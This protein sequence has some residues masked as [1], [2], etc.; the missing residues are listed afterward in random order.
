MKIVGI[1]GLPRSGKDSL[2][3]Q[4]MNGGYFGVSLGDIVRDESRKR[5]SAAKDPISVAN[6]TETANWLRQNQGPDFALKEALNRYER[7]QAAAE[8]I[9]MVVFSVR[10]PVEVD[11]IL[12]HHGELIWVE[13]DDNVRHERMLKHLRDGE[14]T[15][16]QDEFKR[17]ES[18]QW[19]PQAGTPTEAQ[20]DIAYVKSKATRVLANNSDNI[21]EFKQT[22]NILI[23]EI[24]KKIA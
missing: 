15:I 17:Q 5:H 12:A 11:F 22:A 19:R 20:M 3:E 10:A 13:A 7:T 8:Y 16:S 18:L 4:F 23:D 24:N 6:M 2:A 14:K 21:E 1:G 9:G